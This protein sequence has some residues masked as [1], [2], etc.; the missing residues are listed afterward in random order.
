[1]KKVALPSKGEMIDNHFGHCEKFTIYSLSEENEIVDSEYYK[2][3]ETC[4]CK[5]DLAAE[6]GKEGVKVL[7]AG[8]I[9]QGAINKLKAEGIEV[10]SGYQGET[11]LVLEQWLSGYKGNYS[12]C[13]PHESHEGKCHESH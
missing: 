6:L 8:G 7:L 9:G 5:S 13:P 10:F 3:P 2:A 11:K 12:V 1:M 4:G